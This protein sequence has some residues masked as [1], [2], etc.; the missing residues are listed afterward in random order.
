MLCY[1]A[2]WLA[3]CHYA[4]CRYAESRGAVGSPFLTK[5]AA[6]DQRS[7]LSTDSEKRLITWVP[8]SEEGQE[9]EEVG[10][11]AADGEGAGE[12]GVLDPRQVLLR[13]NPE[14]GVREFERFVRKFE[15][16][17]R[18]VEGKA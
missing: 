13:T 5:M 2:E 7:S 14:S 16:F 4:R 6:S 3:E 11:G 8:V 12:D 9:E 1:Y 18:K 17:V 15:R 10:D